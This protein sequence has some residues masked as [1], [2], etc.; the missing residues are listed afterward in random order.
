M[1]ETT[2]TIKAKMEDQQMRI[3]SLERD[4]QEL[5]SQNYKLMVRISELCD[6]L[7]R[8]GISLNNLS[9]F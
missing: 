6:E 4:I 7:R 2:D 3:R 9:K 8:S 5:T 1:T